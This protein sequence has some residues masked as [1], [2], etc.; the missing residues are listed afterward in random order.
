MWTYEKTLHDR[1]VRPTSHFLDETARKQPGFAGAR[2][3]AFEP[4]IVASLVYVHD[5]PALEFELDVWL[6]GIGLDAAEPV[7][8]KWQDVG[9][10]LKEIAIFEMS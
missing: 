1:W 3:S 10:N 4:A 2:M 8:E 9:I 7:D 5:V 6:R